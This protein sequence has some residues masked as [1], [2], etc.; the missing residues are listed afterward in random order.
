MIVVARQGRKRENAEAVR[1][2]LQLLGAEN[3]AIVIS[4][5][6]GGDGYGAGYGYGYY[7]ATTN[8]RT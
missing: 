2:M 7:T 8:Q 1:G 6:S 4:E 3:V 5:S